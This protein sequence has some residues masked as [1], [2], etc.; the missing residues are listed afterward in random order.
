MRAINQATELPGRLRLYTTAR[1][2]NGSLITVIDWPEIYLFLF[3]RSLKNRIKR[4][5]RTE[6]AQN[7][8]RRP[9]K[10][11]RRLNSYCF[12]P[13]FFPIL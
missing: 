11:R 4:A 7:K 1:Q 13:I 8:S 5:L 9:N 3:Y 2:L 6:S 12:V 10:R